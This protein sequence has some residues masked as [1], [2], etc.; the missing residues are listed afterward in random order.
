M[1][2][3]K[4]VSLLFILLL[5]CINT[6][7]Q[8]CSDFPE[9]ARYHNFTISIGGRMY[10]KAE[11]K[12]TYGNYASHP[13]N[14]ITYSFGFG[15]EFF[16]SNKW[17]AKTGLNFASVPYEN[18]DIIILQKDVHPILFT[19]DI[20]NPFREFSHLSLSIPLTIQYKLK[21][22]NNNYLSINAGG[23]ALYML[24]TRYKSTVSAFIA[25]G[26]IAEVYA[27]QL[28]SAGNYFHGGFTSGCSYYLNLNKVLLEFRF[29]YTSMFQN[30]FEGEYQYA[31]L[32][33]SSPTRG[34]FKVS[35]DYLEFSVSTHFLKKKFRTKKK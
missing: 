15:Y 1:V 20:V 7:S 21:L 9:L 28:N 16:T 29:T 34:T 3:I 31:N 33:V 6:F 35:G 32:L 22:F 12:K 5:N 25:D 19:R 26:V 10:E 24:P 2:K 13:L 11:K 4:T 8:K 27:T 18:E 23:L 14:P 30:L 17:S